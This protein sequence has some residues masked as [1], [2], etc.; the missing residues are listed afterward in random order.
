MKV[1]RSLAALS[2][3]LFV[4]LCPLLFASEASATTQEEHDAQVSSIQ[5]TISSLNAQILVARATLA[6]DQETSTARAADSATAYADWV[7]AKNNYQNNLIPQTTITTSGVHIDVYNQAYHRSRPDGV[8]C[9]SDTIT[10]IAQN[11]GNGSVAGCSGDYV[12]IHYTAVLIVPTTDTYRFKNIADDG[13]YMTLGGQVV[14]NEW[15]DKGCNGNWG[16]PIT[17]QANTPYVLD[18]WFYEWGGGACST[19]Y[20]QS[21]TNWAQVPAN[22]YGSDSQTVVVQDP[23]FLTIVHQKKAVRSEEHTSELQSHSFI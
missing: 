21:S 5:E 6:S 2:S 15:Y 18:A 11:W 7:T 17:L 13:F 1:L 22:W 19:L 4:A 10:A 9:K 14:I 20:Y 16:A 3:V 12:L 23:S 8:L